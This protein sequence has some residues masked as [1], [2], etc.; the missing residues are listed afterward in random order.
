MATTNNPIASGSTFTLDM[1]KDSL[2]TNQVQKVLLAE[3]AGGTF[4]TPM[5]QTGGSVTVIG[6]TTM[7]TVTPVVTSNGV[8]AAGHQ[9]GGLMTFAVGG[10]GSGALMSIRVTSR[11]VLTTG[12]NAYIFTTNP[13]NTT[14]TNN[15]AP[16]INA[17]DI[18][19]LLGNV[20]LNSPDSGLGTVTLWS[21]SPLGAQFVGANLYVVL[22]VISG[23]TLTST[24][25]SDITVQL[26]I[27]DD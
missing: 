5:Q 6:R 13:T 23:A 27:R 3:P 8:Y 25:A 16:A 21:G 24:S 26:G 15:T 22:T 18:A 11:S 2:T 19:S 20:L 14:W 7:A 17:A 1:G 10:A 4:I 9:I 12:L